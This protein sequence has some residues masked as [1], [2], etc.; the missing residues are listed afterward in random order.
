MYVDPT[1]DRLLNTVSAEDA[2]DEQ[3]TNNNLFC[4]QQERTKILLLRRKTSRRRPIEILAKDQIHSGCDRVAHFKETCSS[5]SRQKTFS[6]VTE[7]KTKANALP[8]SDYLLSVL[9]SD[10]CYLKPTIML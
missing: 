8:L 3:P 4:Y 10:P 5:S 1:L 9:A 2:V 7:Q 6:A